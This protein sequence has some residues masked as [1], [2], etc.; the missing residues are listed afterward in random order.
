M[1][2][3]SCLLTLCLISTAQ[4][5]TLNDRALLATDPTFF[6]RVKAA[7]LSQAITVSI[8]PAATLEH[9][10]RDWL[11]VQVLTDSNLWASRFVWAAAAA[12]PAM[13]GAATAGG[14]VALTP[15]VTTCDGAMPPVCN[16]SGNLAAR[17][18]LVTDASI[19]SAV[20]AGWNS[21]FPH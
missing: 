9:S 2:W 18:A 21:F 4:A 19:I 12:D 10:N 11:A 8:E 1:L 3:K 5:Q 7:I 15:N 17:A 13:V 20:S 6:L 14:T 16:T